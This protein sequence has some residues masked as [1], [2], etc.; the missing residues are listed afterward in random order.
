MDAVPLSE[1]PHPAK[2]NG[3]KG[4]HKLA[5]HLEQAKDVRLAILLQN[6]SAGSP[7]VATPVVALSNW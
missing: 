3:N 4:V 2:Q 7:L 1:S 6:T 5:I